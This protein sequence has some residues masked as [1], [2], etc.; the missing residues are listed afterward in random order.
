MPTLQLATSAHPRWRIVRATAQSQSSTC[1]N[2]LSSSSGHTAGSSNIPLSR[3]QSRTLPRGPVLLVCQS[4]GR[5]WQGPT[6]PTGIPTVDLAVG[7]G[8]SRDDGGVAPHHPCFMSLRPYLVAADTRHA[9]E[10]TDWTLH[11]SGSIQARDSECRFQTNLQG[12]ERILIQAE[13]ATS[14]S[15]VCLL[16][17]GQPQQGQA[18]FTD[19]RL[20]ASYPAG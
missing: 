15:I 7:F 2:R 17:Q 6:Q 18:L 9:L 8:R 3:L 16:P 10:A 1:A 13:S 19:S 11:R 4:G 5:S 20:T 12:E 14:K